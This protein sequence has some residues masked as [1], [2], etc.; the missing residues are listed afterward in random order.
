M[1][2]SLLNVALLITVSTLT[3]VACSSNTQRQ[4]TTA[5]AVAGAVLGG[6]AGSAIG[7]G[8]GKLVAIGAGAIAGGLLGGA[9]GRDMDSVDKQKIYHTLDHNQK[10]KSSRWKNKDGTKYTMTPLTNTIVYKGQRPC[11]KYRATITNSG[12]RKVERGIACRQP[13]GTWK[14]TSA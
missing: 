9:I 5:G 11:R 2:S 4:N 13:N 14:V 8:T 12:E 1:K 3:L 10:R 7:A 6:V